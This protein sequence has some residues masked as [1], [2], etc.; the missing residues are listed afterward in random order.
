M[1]ASSGEE[2]M[3]IC[4]AKGHQPDL[5]ILDLSMP[6]MG[7][8]KALKEM[9]AINPGAKVLIASGYSRNGQVK[10]TLKSGAAGY[11]TKPFRR[12]ELLK[13]VREVLDG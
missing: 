11:I 4:R 9:L 5:V 10:D 8:H 12:G 13:T 6:G 1:T 7:G 3:D 2:A